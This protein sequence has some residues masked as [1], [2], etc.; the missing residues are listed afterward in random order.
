MLATSK[1][2][3]GM[4]LK[5][6]VPAGFLASAAVADNFVL[7]VDHVPPVQGTYCDDYA[8][9]EA[10]RLKAFIGSRLGSFDIIDA[11]CK[12]QDHPTEIEY[13]N[14]RITYSA[15]SKLPVV[16]TYDDTV[17]DQPGFAT[18]SACDAA[19]PAEGNAFTTKTGLDVFSAYCFVPG[20]TGMLWSKVITGFGDA[21]VRPF[22]ANATIFGSME[23]STWVLF[24]QTL[25]ANLS[26][27]GFSMHDFS[28]S[29]N[30]GYFIATFRY[31]GDHQ[32]RPE[33]VKIARF[34]VP[35][36]CENAVQT[37]NVALQQAKTINY[38]AYCQDAGI[39]GPGTDL[40][41]FGE[42]QFPPRLVNSGR[43]YTTYAVCLNELPQVLDHYRQNLHRDMTAGF[44]T[45]DPDT[46]T[47]KIIMI[48][49]RTNVHAE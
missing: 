31:Y 19:L 34:D 38:I 36:D 23:N 29:N 32:I 9:S 27:M 39:F 43:S 49:T 4:F 41:T 12:Q 2:R 13:W 44:C 3:V 28:V 1:Y 8:V 17:L 21:A 6:I 45:H 30:T 16:S 26:K 7:H 33:P 40:V 22:T 18:K 48:E 24:Q 20:F 47:F 42:R 15:P 35:K 37:T 11:R 10:A 46:K 5:V 14:L 25:T